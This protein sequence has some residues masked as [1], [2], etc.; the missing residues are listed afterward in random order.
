MSSPMDG[1]DITMSPHLA[2]AAQ[3]ARMIV[4]QLGG[5]WSGSK[6]QCRCPAHDDS[7]PS[8]SVRLGRKAIL[9]RCFAGCDT[10]DVLSALRRGH[11]YDDA[12]L[13]MPP[14]RP[15]KD[16]S[17]LA[18]QLWQASVPIAGT[19]AADYLALRG[20][21]GPYPASLRY[22]PATVLGLGARRRVLPAMIAAVENSLGLVAVQR[23]FLDPEDLSR[24]P[25]ARNKV[26]LG[27]L[28]EGAIRLAPV[29]DEL[30]LAEGIEDAMTAMAWF[31]TPT[32]AL[33]G[34]ERLG[35][36]EFPPGVR[37]V[38][39]F[40]D[41]GPATQRVLRRVHDHVTADGRALEVKIPRHYKDWNEAWCVRHRAH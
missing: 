26:A 29:E 35:R 10:A 30:G 21:T 19:P 20:L 23:T 18:R 3:R 27:L 14:A 33:G 22:N 12:P 28:G 24:K 1:K 38:T 34:L 2:D 37:R 17:A 6:G 41:Q 8:L 32:W 7:T 5:R 11:L 25:F 13:K 31:R 40:G 9:F 15:D 16:H 39:L 36:L 4:E